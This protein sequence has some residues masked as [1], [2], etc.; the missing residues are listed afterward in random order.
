M[1]A[2]G[3]GENAVKTLRNSLIALLVL[4][5]IVYRAHRWLIARVLRLTPPK[6]RVAVE[7]GL[8]IPM[9]DG[10]TLAADHYAPKAAGQFPTILIRSPYGRTARAGSFGLL[11][12]FFGHRFAERGYHVLI[13]DTRGRFDSQGVFNPYF[14]ES[15]DGHATLEWL[16]SQP[17]SNG[18]IGLWGGSY[19]G[20]VQW[21][22]AADSPAVKA[23]MPAITS[24]QL[25]KIVYPDG[26]L[27]LGLA[28]RWM[29][30]FNR[31][32]QARTNPLK[33][34]LLLWDVEKTIQPALL[35]LPM[36]EA[37]T[38]ALG[39]KVDFF[40]DWI[41]HSDMSDDL[42]RENVE[43]IK[44]KQVTQPTY[45]MSG[46]YD[47]FLRG[48]LDDYATLR[49]LGRRPYLTIG[50][51]H[52]FGAITSMADLREGLVWFDA[53]LYDDRSRLREKPVRIFV[54]GANEWRDMDSF[55]PPSTETRYYLQAAS[56]LATEPAH[57]LAEPTHYTYDPS[58]PTPAVGGAIFSILGGRRDNR[59]LE[60]RSDVRTYTT[61]PLREAVEII[62]RVRLEL[63][64]QSSL[65]Y[66]DFFGRLCDVHPDERSFNICEGLFRVEPGK[67]AKQP[68]G[69]MCVEIDMWATA[70]RFQPGHSIRLQ[71]SSGAHPHW[72][73]NL[74]TGEYFGTCTTC[75]V[76]EQT[77][78]HD[79]LHPSALVL[80]V[81]K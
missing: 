17:W 41:Q 20:I 53:H 74:G 57:A 71:V 70:H 11:L 35:H 76:A 13:Q 54:M 66:T 80:P 16:C 79:R 36:V 51:W 8:R 2:R 81:I 9:R 46:W 43:K 62:G 38:I 39:S 30:I 73:R 7:H 59:A 4:A 14:N 10:L 44:L 72:S 56:M 27:D 3:N 69:S 65:E 28:L 25:Q 49:D 40:H 22:I 60:A 67:V 21:V 18:V 19:L 75:K 64:A 29:T 15:D 58:D 23:I 33:S 37:D 61:S 50:P 6:Y 52:H 5:V 32:D 26:A 48:T 78:Y 24:T 31:L 77:I 12:G 45:L 63:Y 47:F 34:L 55:P 1:L 68:D 42:W